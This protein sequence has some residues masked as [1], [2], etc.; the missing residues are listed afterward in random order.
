MKYLLLS[1]A[2]SSNIG[3]NL[4]K[5]LD[6]RN[7]RIP[8]IRNLCLSTKTHDLGILDHG[9]NHV[10]QTVREDLGIGVD[11]EYYLVEVWRNASDL[12]DTVEHLELELRHTFVKHNLLQERHENDLTVTLST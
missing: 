4:L 3:S 12:P 7:P 2:R 1:V 10:C 8:L 11:H 6:H 9:G 5:H